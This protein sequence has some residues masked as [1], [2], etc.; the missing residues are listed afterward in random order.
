V[1]HEFDLN[2]IN[3]VEVIYDVEGTKAL[4]HSSRMNRMCYVIRA[5]GA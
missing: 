3:I 5:T 2:R 1:P 4:I